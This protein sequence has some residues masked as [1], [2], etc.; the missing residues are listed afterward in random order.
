[1]VSFFLAK[2][3]NLS[4]YLATF[5]MLGIWRTCREDYRGEINCRTEL[6]DSFSRLPCATL[7]LKKVATWEAEAKAMA[8]A[9]TF[10]RD[11]PS[12]SYF[13]LIIN[14]RIDLIHFWQ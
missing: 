3:A 9:K 7:S 4:I 1:M 8:Q 13:L 11:V 12:F 14:S 5:L 10:G 6:I 2:E